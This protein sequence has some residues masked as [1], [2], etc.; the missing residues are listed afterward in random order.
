[1]KLKL[2]EKIPEVVRD[3]GVAAIVFVVIGAFAHWRIGDPGG[4]WIC[5]AIGFGGTAWGYWM[6]TRPV[7][8]LRQEWEGQLRRPRAEGLGVVPRRHR[9]W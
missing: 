8:Q 7:R 5:A 2:L 1:M 9:R 6:G 3:L 4:V